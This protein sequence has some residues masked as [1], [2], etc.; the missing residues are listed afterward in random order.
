MQAI[1]LVGGWVP[2]RA[3][4]YAVKGVPEADIAAAT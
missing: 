3:L 4:R 1:L 2:A